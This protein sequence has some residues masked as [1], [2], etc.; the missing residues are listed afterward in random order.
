M[1]QWLADLF[2]ALPRALTEPY[3]FGSLCLAFGWLCYAADIRSPIT[4]AVR[5]RCG[6]AF[7]RVNMPHVW[8]RIFYRLARKK[9]KLDEGSVY[10]IN[11]LSLLLLMVTT[12]IHTAL[13][14][15]CVK[16]MAAAITAD[17]ILLT[18]TLCII[19]V[20]ALITQPGATMERRERW[21]FRKTGNIVRAVLREILIVA[22]LFLWLY[23]AWFLPALLS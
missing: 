5:A 4:R 15:L 22:V 8:Q 9:A 6:D 17:K 19:S 14:V 20:L 13:I 23:D 1:N 12:L 7:M 3:V 11:L 10:L 16:D 18:V 2:F 21:G